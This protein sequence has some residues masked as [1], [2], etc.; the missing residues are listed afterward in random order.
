LENAKV[1]AF[2]SADFYAYISKN[3][4]PKEE[5]WEFHKTP[6]GMSFRNNL[7]HKRITPYLKNNFIFVYAGMGHLYRN[8]EAGSLTDRLREDGVNTVTA[9]LL[10]RF[11]L[12]QE[13]RQR[14]PLETFI[15]TIPAEYKDDM[16]CDYVIIYN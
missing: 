6:E 12:T 8:G 10:N 4:A 1:H 16:G 11:F 5:E 14:L 13:T 7:W 3:E 9:F 15:L 2:T